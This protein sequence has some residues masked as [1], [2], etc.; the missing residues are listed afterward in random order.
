MLLGKNGK[1]ARSTPKITSFAIKNTLANIPLK[2]SI[3][4]V[5]PEQENP[6][7]KRMNQSEEY[8]NPLESSIMTANVDSEME[9]KNED[10]MIRIVQPSNQISKIIGANFRR[11]Q[12]L[13][14]NYQKYN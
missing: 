14:G 11:I 6:S 7:T 12:I 13:K 4:A 3:S 10:K 2:R 9:G 1:S 8:N 5:S